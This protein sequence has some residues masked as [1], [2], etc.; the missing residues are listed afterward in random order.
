MRIE[1]GIR[2][3]VII[4][5]VNFLPYN[6]RT[7]GI[8]WLMLW[9][10]GIGFINLRVNLICLDMVIWSYYIIM[11]CGWFWNSPSSFSR[12]RD[13]RICFKR[14][15]SHLDNDKLFSFKYITGKNQVVVVQEDGTIH[16]T[17]AVSPEK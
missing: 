17:V 4:Y 7:V 10:M 16:D 12:S 14:S 1:L 6:I 15:S 11:L 9:C 5:L 3:I 2:T 13:N 8:S